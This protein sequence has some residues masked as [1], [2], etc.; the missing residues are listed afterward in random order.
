MRTKTVVAFTLLAMVGILTVCTFRPSATAYERKMMEPFIK[1]MK[2]KCYGRFLLDVPQSSIDGDGDHYDYAFATILTAKEPSTQALFDARIDA[3]EA[4]NQEKKTF[5]GAAFLR[6][7]ERIDSKLRWLAFYRNELG[8]AF[9]IRGFVLKDQRL[10]TV[11][12]GGSDDEDLQ[13][14]RREF[15]ALAPHLKPLALDATPTGP[16]FCMRGGYIAAEDRRG[17]SVNSGFEVPQLPELYFSVSTS[18]NG[19]NIDPG[20]LD[21]EGAIIAQ[22]GSLIS[23]VKTIRKGRRTINGMEAQE[24]ISKIPPGDEWEYSFDLVIPGKPNS[25]AAPNI[26]LTMKLEGVESNGVRAP[27]KMSE[28]EALLLWDAITSTLRLRPGAL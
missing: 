12:A 3:M 5:K 17:E 16:G 22:L 9:E 10:F 1:S 13:N 4:A 8:V 27:V 26:S 21:R 14:F 6:H 7:A 15:I 19:D 25:N 2:T 28:A 18:T 20:P 23:Q 24:W 11:E